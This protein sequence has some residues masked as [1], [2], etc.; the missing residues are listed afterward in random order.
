MY[1]SISETFYPQE[2]NLV[3]CVSGLGNY[4]TIKF[5]KHYLQRPIQHLIVAKKKRAKEHSPLKYET[6]PNSNTIE[7]CRMSQETVKKL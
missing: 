6:K 3:S 1:P 4:D 2:S 7:L 5:I